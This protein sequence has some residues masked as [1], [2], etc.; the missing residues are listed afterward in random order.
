M[1]ARRFKWT[2]D[3]RYYGL[4]DIVDAYDRGEAVDWE[5]DYGEAEAMEVS[6][7]SRESGADQ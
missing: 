7:T 6:E 3:G 2:A 1:S 5:N 4:V